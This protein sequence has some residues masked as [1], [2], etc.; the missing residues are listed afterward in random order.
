[1]D[2][3]EEA[4]REMRERNLAARNKKQTT[5][6]SRPVEGAKDPEEVRALKKHIAELQKRV[7][8]LEAENQR[9]RTQ[10]T[11]VVERTSQKSADDELREQRHNF[12]KY[13][14][15]RRY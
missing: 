5:Q 1:M 3:L 7:H 8:A 4:Q 13:S 9:L 15:V 12:F 11:V 6:V 10:K 2:N 14:N